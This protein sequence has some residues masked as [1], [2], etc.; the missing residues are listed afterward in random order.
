[1]SLFCRQE[2]SRAGLADDRRQ[3]NCLS[4]FKSAPA[5]PATAPGPSTSRS[6]SST[7]TCTKN[8]HQH[9]RQQPASAAAPA[10]AAATATAAAAITAA[11]EAMTTISTRTNPRRKQ[12]RQT[13]VVQGSVYSRAM[14]LMASS[15]RA[16]TDLE[17]QWQ[18]GEATQTAGII[19]WPG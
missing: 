2:A 19:K 15:S 17:A 9:Q 13:L 12:R 8:Q 6:S 1:M 16:C 5:Q 14:I 3:L 11:T 10:A 4:Q 7:S 18:V